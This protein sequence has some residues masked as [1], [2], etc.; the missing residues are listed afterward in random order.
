[1]IDTNV[2][3][4]AALRPASTPRCAFDLA[5]AKGLVLISEATLSELNDVLSRPKFARYISEASRLEFLA[6]YIRDARVITVI[7]SIDACRDA[8]DNK[9]LEVAVCG[10]ATAIVTGD[11]DLLVLNPFRGIHVLTPEQFVEG[12]WIDSSD[13]EE[14]FQLSFPF[15]VIG[16]K[17]GEAVTFPIG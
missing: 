9:F 11:N 12:C 6:A 7:E 1:M 5:L 15:F 4:S 14:S 3:I 2:L 13:K 8:K 16:T 10:Q 17:S